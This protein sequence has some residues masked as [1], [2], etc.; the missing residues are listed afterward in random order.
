MASQNPRF[1]TARSRSARARAQRERARDNISRCET[2]DSAR[3]DRGVGRAHL[4]CLRGLWSRG[5]A[6]GSEK[7]A[8][9]RRVASG[10]SRDQRQR[11]S[12]GA[13]GVGRCGPGGQKNYVTNFALTHGCTER[14][15]LARCARLATPPRSRPKYFARYL[16]SR[17]AD[18]GNSALARRR[19]SHANYRAEKSARIPPG[20]PRN[21][22]DK[23][24]RKN[25]HE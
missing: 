22:R 4:W 1:A 12:D 15:G 25:R 14:L 24:S 19:A 13:S 20:R 23:P 9:R 18:R 11:T 21:R 2:R 6:T 16:A 5:R 7:V 3:R 8:A 17:R 10:E